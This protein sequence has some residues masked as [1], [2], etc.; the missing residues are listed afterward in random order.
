[1]SQSLDYRVRDLYSTPTKR[2]K[3]CCFHPK[4]PLLLI[5]EYEGEISLYD[6]TMKSLIRTFNHH[7]GSVRSI[8]IHSQYQDLA[9]SCADDNTVVLFDLKKGTVL[10]RFD[11]F[12]DYVRCVRFH[13]KHPWIA[14]CGDDRTVRIFDVESRKCI[15]TL[16][17]HTK[18]VMSCCFHPELPLLVSGSLDETIRVWDI[19]SLSSHITDGNRGNVSLLNLANGCFCRD[20]LAGHTDAVNYVDFHADQPNT[21]ISCADDCT[22]RLWEVSRM[23]VFALSILKGHTRDIT[24]VVSSPHHNHLIVSVS[25][26]KTLRLWDTSDLNHLLVYRRQDH[27]RYWHVS[28]HPKIPLFCACHD[29]GF[30]VFRL[31]R[32]TIPF[33]ID[34]ESNKLFAS[35]DG[36]TVRAIP[37]EEKPSSTVFRI[38][39]SNHNITN[40]HVHR[41]VVYANTRLSQTSNTAL[42]L[43]KNRHG[44]YTVD[45]QLEDCIIQCISH[46]RIVKYQDGKL[47]LCNNR[48]DHL[49]LITSDFGCTHLFPYKDD[50]A[51]FIYHNS[52][53]SL[54]STKVGESD[55]LISEFHHSALRSLTWSPDKNYC[56]I[57]TSHTVFVYNANMRSCASD[58]NQ[59]FVTHSGVWLMNDG[60]LFI[61]QRGL[62]S[63]IVYERDGTVEMETSLIKT[64]IQSLQPMCARIESTNSATLLSFNP[65]GTFDRQTIPLEELNFKLAVIRGNG[66]MAAQYLSKIN[67]VGSELIGFCKKHGQPEIGMHVEP[68]PGL[69][70]QF[71]LCLE[72]N[73]F[74][75]ALQL[76]REHDLTVVQQRTFLKTCIRN[77]KINYLKEL[78]QDRLAFLLSILLGT[79]C[80]NTHSDDTLDYMIAIIF[81]EHL[82]VIKTLLDWDMMG[83]AHLYCQRISEEDFET[84]ADLETYRR[85][86]ASQMEE[87]KLKYTPP[88]RI[89]RTNEMPKPIIDLSDLEVKTRRQPIIPITEPVDTVQKKITEEEYLEAPE[90]EPLE[91]EEQKGTLFGDDLSDDLSDLDISDLD[92][93]DETY[94]DYD[95]NMSAAFSIPPVFKSARECHQKTDVSDLIL[96]QRT[97]TVVQSLEHVGIDDISKPAMQEIFKSHQLSGVISFGLVNTFSF[98]N[99]DQLKSPFSFESILELIESGDTAIIAGFSDKAYEVYH[100]AL[101]LLPLC[102]HEDANILKERCRT[103][104]MSVKLTRA[105]EE[106][107]TKVNSDPTRVVELGAH[108]SR[109]INPAHVDDVLKMVLVTAYKARLFSVAAQFARQIIERGVCDDSL[110][111]KCHKIIRKFEQ[112]GKDGE[113][114]IRYDPM[115][116]ADIDPSSLLPISATVCQ[117]AF[118]GSCY[119]EVVEGCHV[120]DLGRISVVE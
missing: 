28:V 113:P 73:D 14:G 25:V 112:V 78:A 23:S 104:I 39:N 90:Q 10:K 51:F 84:D 6:F 35:I 65:N 12:E 53:L 27:K 44:D 101:T 43:K 45:F 68:I 33:A 64:T 7:N 16:S 77:G 52:K 71:N 8:D 108:L 29:G 60:G 38:P 100:H 4:K 15:A 61:T 11:D 46:N 57:I 85:V 3:C 88:Q 92:E 2:A 32:S 97:N 120:C 47:W 75:T 106:E 105:L 41:D 19:S 74:E 115:T 89:V 5:S 62:K 93:E 87:G 9:V 98:P 109:I 1:M 114:I 99:D 20:V 86:L 110:K 31:T 116:V 22:L 69:N 79:R 82:K 24:A 102:S 30:D 17:G 81:K 42:V 13:P 118:C 72:S 55:P 119:G 26:D 34:G 94:V 18:Y 80:D 58:T 49:G 50:S 70:E 67:A 21:L 66:N 59:V 36:K 91:P 117:C 103:A 37:F 40:M 111:K 63:F 107:R 96:L 76:F 95:T 48:F 56:M 54:I 83:L